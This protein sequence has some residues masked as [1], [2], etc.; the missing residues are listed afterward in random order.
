MNREDWPSEL[1]MSL[2]EAKQKRRELLTELATE[3]ARKAEAERIASCSRGRRCRQSACPVCSYWQEVASRGLRQSAES[4]S[5]I[6]RN[7]AHLPIDALKVM[8][9]RR[10]IDPAKVRLIAASMAMIGQ[11]YP[12]IVREVKKK[13]YVIAGLH[14][15]EAAR[16]LG[17]DHIWCTYTLGGADDVEV[18]MILISENLH[19]ADLRVL[20]RAEYIEEWRRLVRERARGGTNASPVVPGSPRLPGG[21]Q[22]GEGGIK[23]TARALGLTP[24]EVRR[25][26]VIA[27]LSPEAKD[28]ARQ[29]RLDNSQHILV[30]VGKLP[31]GVQLNA[32][33][34]QAERRTAKTNAHIP[35]AVQS[36]LAE[37]ARLRSTITKDEERLNKITATVAANKRLLA[38]VTAVTHSDA[39]DDTSTD[40]ARAAS[41]V[42]PPTVP[43]GGFASAPHANTKFTARSPST[44]QND[45]LLPTCGGDSSPDLIHLDADDQQLLDDLLARWAK[46]PVHVRQRF[47]SSALTEA[48]G[49]ENG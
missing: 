43:S 41:V 1:A 38:D 42:S 35:L 32:L 12:I 25:A 2:K 17:W 10:P 14:K 30:A 44:D 21:M 37:A 33:R 26:K 47:V 39:A 13:F 11:L 7:G 22:P 24:R 8:P 36:A 23:K 15:L 5:S 34:D 46:A 28:E 6:G 49:A 45:E 48:R 29:L 16:S 27:S 3:P 18:R 19:R 4:V 31:A 40:G 9:N 20:D